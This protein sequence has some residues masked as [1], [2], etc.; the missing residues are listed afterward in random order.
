MRIAKTV[1]VVWIGATVMPF[2]PAAVAQGQSNAVG[3]S[4]LPAARAIPGITSDDQ[5]ATACVG[6]HVNYKEVAMDKRLSTVMRDWATRGVE[7][8]IL[9]VARSVWG[10]S[11]E[12]AG[13]HPKVD[14]AREEI[15]AVCQECHDSGAN[16]VMALAPFLH[17]IHLDSGGEAIFLRIFQG[18][19]THCHKLNK[20][21]G[22]WSIPSASESESE[23]IE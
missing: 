17:K 16:K 10:P 7:T 3:T 23:M 5:F 20:A 9:E 12:L 19:C 22:Q 13:I 6:C 2:A 8:E 1:L 15:P 4:G 18:E 21:T 11:I 14:V